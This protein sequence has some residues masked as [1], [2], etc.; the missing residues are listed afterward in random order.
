MRKYVVGIYK[1]H[2][3]DVVLSL[4]RTLSLSCSLLFSL[5]LPLVRVLSF[6]CVFSR[7]FSCMHSLAFTTTHTLLLFLAIMRTLPFSLAM[8]RACTLFH[9]HAGCTGMRAMLLCELPFLVGQVWCS[10]LQCIVVRCSVLQCVAQGCV[11]CCSA[12]S[13]FS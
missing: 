9:T 3:R 7:A 1:T 11:L 12:S 2:D 6:A 5:A 13:H 10:V 4:A 8:M